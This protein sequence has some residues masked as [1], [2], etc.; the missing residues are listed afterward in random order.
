MQYPSSLSRSQT[1]VWLST[2]DDVDPG[3]SVE[4][5]LLVVLA[6]D[7]EDDVG[8]VDDDDNDDDDEVGIEVEE[9]V[10]I[11]VEDDD[12]VAEEVLPVAGSTQSSSKS[13][14]QSKNWAHK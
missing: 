10:G 9:D 8:I 3:A 11:E 4:V 14:Q 1:E 13:S 5:E 12:G 6:M 2:S 7:V